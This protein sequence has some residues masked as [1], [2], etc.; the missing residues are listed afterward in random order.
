L[1]ISVDWPSGADA[2]LNKELGCTGHL[3]VCGHRYFAS[4]LCVVTLHRYLRICQAC[5]V[6]VGLIFTRK[7][8]QTVFWDVSVGCC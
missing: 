2:T 5:F 6:N 8:P 4:L 7:T 1:W 3:N